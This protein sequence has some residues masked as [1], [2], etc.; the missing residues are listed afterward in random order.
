MT[1]DITVHIADGAYYLVPGLTV[2]FHHGRFRQK[3]TYCVLE[4]HRLKGDHLWWDE[5]YWVVSE[6]ISIMTETKKYVIM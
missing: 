6:S 1:E 3:W 5:G 2:E 4:S